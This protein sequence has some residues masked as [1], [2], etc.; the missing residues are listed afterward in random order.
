[1]SAWDQ[2]RKTTLLYKLKHNEVVNTIPTLG[3]NVETITVGKGV[4]FTVWDVGGQEVLR[5]LW[6]YYYQGSAGLLFVVDS[7][8]RARLQDAREEMMRVLGA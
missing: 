8:D 3:F 4:T 6:R 1:M 7:S 5:N 2:Q